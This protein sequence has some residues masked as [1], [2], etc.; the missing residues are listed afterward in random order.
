M[1]LAECERAGRLERG[2]LVSLTGFG[3]GFTWGSAVVRW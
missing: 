1:L 3:S 2:D